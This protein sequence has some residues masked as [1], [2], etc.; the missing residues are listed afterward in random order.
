MQVKVIHEDPKQQRAERAPLLHPNDA[1][2]GVGQAPGSFHADWHISIQRLQG[3]QHVAPNARTLQLC[4]QQ[5]PIH[6]VEGLFQVHGADVELA[7]WARA[8]STSARKL[9]QL[10][11]VRKPRRKPAWPGARFPLAPA[12]AESRRFSTSA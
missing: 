12:H 1:L 8:R 10:S 3:S 2:E 9:K 6:T 5:L 4:P 11:V 7:P